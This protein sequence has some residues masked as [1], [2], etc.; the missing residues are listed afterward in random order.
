VQPIPMHAL[1]IIL[2]TTVS[3]NRNGTFRSHVITL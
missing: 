2:A 3:H 1:G